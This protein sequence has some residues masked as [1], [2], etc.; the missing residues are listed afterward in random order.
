MND[1]GNNSTNP[2]IFLKP[3][4][5]SYHLNSYEKRLSTFLTCDRFPVHS[6]AVQRQFAAN[7]LYMEFHSDYLLVCKTCLK[8]VLINPNLLLAS[9]SCSDWKNIKYPCACNTALTEYDMLENFLNNWN[10]FTRY[11]PG[12]LLNPKL[13]DVCKR[14]FYPTKFAI[15]K[16]FCC[17]YVVPFIG[18]KH[19]RYCIVEK[20][21]REMVSPNAPICS[22]CHMMPITVR[23]L[24]CTHMSLCALCLISCIKCPISSC[25]ENVQ[26]IEFKN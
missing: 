24:P 11:I 12:H 18:N 13:M 7:G 22:K 3:T 10:F 2:K 20:A 1:V 4:D 25:D 9:T 8:Y 17:N 16:C 21:L 19:S 6:R 15:T 26:C 14:G 23:A 5:L